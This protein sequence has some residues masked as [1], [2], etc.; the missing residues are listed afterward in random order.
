MVSNSNWRKKLFREG[1]T[2][3]DG[4]KWI[5]NTFTN[6][7]VA[8]VGYRK[9]CARPPWVREQIR[10]CCDEGLVCTRM[11]GYNGFCMYPR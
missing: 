1:K 2:L 10:R 5:I 7:V 8:C 6:L 11:A 4:Y 3:V 9:L